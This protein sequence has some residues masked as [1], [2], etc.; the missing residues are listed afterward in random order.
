M[1]RLEKF[2]VQCGIDTGKNIK[3]IIKNGEITI[4]GNVEI[5]ISK[6][7]NTETDIVLY[8]GNKVEIKT[9]KYYIFYKPAGYITAVSNPINSKPIIMDLIPDRICK[10]G[11]SP[12]GRLDKDTEGV[13]ILTNDGHLNHELTKPEKIVEK[14]YY[15]ELLREI[16]EEAIKI[17]EEGVEID[18]YISKPSK[19]QII[20]S[21]AIYLTITEGKYH[22][23]KKMLKGVGNRVE[24][25]KRVRMGKITLGDLKLGE[26]KEIKKED[27]I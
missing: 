13:L 17:L 5:D 14:E 6:K 2:L 8:L 25:L 18:N 24:Y 12:V 22:Q 26:I 23:V 15:V 1:I 27:I 3:K 19:V 20:N 10:Q 9:L 21:K 16:K 11:L 4:N 7:I